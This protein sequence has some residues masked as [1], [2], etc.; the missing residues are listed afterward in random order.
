MLLT[1][2][3]LL[4]ARTPISVPKGPAP[5]IDGVL[6]DEWKDAKTIAEREGSRIL[7]KH[8]GESLYL[9]LE[10]KRNSIASIHLQAGDKIRVLHAS[11]ALGDADYSKSG[12]TWNPAKG[13]VWACRTMNDSAESL[14]EQAK[15][16]KDN[17]WLSNTG[18]QTSTR[19]YKISKKVLGPMAI[20]LYGFQPDGMV[21]SL[22]AT[23][24]DDGL[25]A[26]LIGGWQP[27]GLTFS[28]ETWVTFTLE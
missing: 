14:A 17:G 2:A 15:F 5:K 12:E 13:F 18:A 25:N 6:A 24:S 22:P 9:A 26:R 10:G 7:A 11:A 3:L 8:D 21:V 4:T 1:L 23:V 19:E 28:P 16:Y 20:A 27:Q